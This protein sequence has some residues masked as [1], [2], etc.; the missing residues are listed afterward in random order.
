MLARILRPGFEVSR[1]YLLSE[2]VINSADTIGR[3][4]TLMS[5]LGD[6]NLPQESKSAEICNLYRTEKRYVS[7]L[8]LFDCC[9]NVRAF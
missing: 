9:V 7:I 5:S 8:G 4:K 1:S 3:I 6:G 2:H